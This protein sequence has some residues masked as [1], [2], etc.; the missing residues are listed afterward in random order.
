MAD[1]E[2]LRRELQTQVEAQKTQII[3]LEDEIQ[4]ASDERMRSEVTIATL[5]REVQQLREASADPIAMQAL[6]N[7]VKAL[8]RQ[9]ADLQEEADRERRQRGKLSNDNRKL[10]LDMSS[11]QDQLEEEK[12]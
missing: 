1:L 11:L 4:L 2:R 12:K 8:Q 5:T 9:V 10:Q 6:E 7:K 3:E